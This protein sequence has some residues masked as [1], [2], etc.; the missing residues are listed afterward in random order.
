MPPVIAVTGSSPSSIITDR[1]TRSHVERIDRTY[2]LLLMYVHFGV[3]GFFLVR[4]AESQS[5]DRRVVE[6]HEL[7]RHVATC[8][9]ALIEHY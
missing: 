4:P 1:A 6:S 9:P 3:T 7:L 2:S 5:N 8:N